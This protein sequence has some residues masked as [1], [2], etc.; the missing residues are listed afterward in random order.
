MVGLGLPVVLAPAPAAHAAPF[1]ACVQTGTIK[2][3]NTDSNTDIGFVSK[4]WNSF[5]E[6]VV[7]TT[8]SDYLSVSVPSG[9]EQSITALN[10]QNASFPYV[11]GITG[12]ANTSPNLGPGSSNYAYLGG[13]TATPA[14]SPPVAGAN[15]FTSATGI[16]EP[17][18]SAIWTQQA[19]STLTTAASATVALGGQVHD[20]AT[21][22][23]TTNNA[24]VPQ[25]IN[26][27]SSKPVTHL[28]DI[29][30]ILV[31]TG[32]VTVF[33]NTFGAASNVALTLVPTTT[34]PANPTGTVT[35]KAYGPG[36]TTCANPAVFT[37]TVT[38]SG[39]AN[40]SS[41]NF[42]P[43]AAGAYRFVAAYSGDGNTAPASTACTDPAELVTVT[44]AV[45][46]VTTAATPSSPIGSP[47]SDTAT[48]APATGVA[49][50]T[51]TVTFTLF[52]NAGCTGTPVFTSSNRPLA[53]GPPPTAMS[54]TF[55]PAAVGTYR[56]VAAYAGDANYAPVTAACGAPNETSTV[57]KVSP[58]ISTQA[59]AGNLLGAP[60]RDVATI[61]GGSSPT[62]TVTFSLFPTSACTSSVFTSTNPLSGSSATSDWFTPATAGTYYWTAAYSG[63]AS[64][65]GVTSAC[66]APNESVTLAPFAA[67]APTQT[68]TGDF[69][70]PLNVAA[71]QSVLITNARV[72][73]P[74]T[75]APGGALTVV[76]SQVSRGITASAPAFLSLC[77][78][79]VSSPAGGPALS[80]SDAGV[81]IR[82][83]D[84]AAGCAGN[85][86]SGDVNLTRNLALT[87]GTDIVA[88]N[89]TVNNGGPGN[90]VV[91]AANVSGALACAG[92]T[93]APTNAGQ[94]NTAASK[95]GQC[96]TL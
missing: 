32:D 19:S 73:G 88:G 10:G 69:Q 20:T 25:W 12:F 13:T 66:N 42:T 81:P 37:N 16:P 77:G 62:G 49:A 82:I 47:I 34:C 17:I 58:T 90:T 63:D 51:G 80:V 33:Q 78:A 71:G 57:T 27:D 7:T 76:N 67:P 75:V 1:T 43:T 4:T 59:S 36:D 29:T 6:F 91:K 96:A 40:Y 68:V 28:V 35:F 65:N 39:A 46:S 70:G 55:T 41:A 24:L 23:A 38:V 9:S 61:G 85:R 95:S 94:V 83:G 26:T 22:G 21:L 8:P 48:V 74:V 64:N 11:G 92:N 45:P 54:A 53:G 31:I 60:A 89:T 86:F 84:P 14:G 52:D 30:N 5:G 44:A 56:W 15:A 50:P 18:E 79:Q 3:T 87:F 72:I 2:V 93:P